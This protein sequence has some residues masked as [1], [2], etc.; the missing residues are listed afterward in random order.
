MRQ[1][2]DDLCWDTIFWQ[3]FGTLHYF[4]HVQKVVGRVF[5]GLRIGNQLQ[6][7]GP[8]HASLVNDLC[9]VIAFGQWSSCFDDYVDYRSQFDPNF[10]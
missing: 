9:G 3:L 1:P 8:P 5:P 7:D 4:V 6:H 10:W 2:S